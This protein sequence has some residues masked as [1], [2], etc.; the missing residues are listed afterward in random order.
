MSREEDKRSNTPTSWMDQFKQST[1]RMSRAMSELVTFRNSQLTRASITVM[2]LAP[3][4]KVLEVGCGPGHALKLMGA[5]VV[6]GL[7]AGIDPLKEMVASAA[8][9]N[10]PL[11]KSGRIILSRGDPEKIPFGDNCFNKAVTINTIHLWKSKAAGFSEMRRVLCPEG[12]MVIG[13]KTATPSSQSLAD[14]GFTAEEIIQLMGFIEQ[15]GFTN[16]RDAR[17]EF[18]EDECMLLANV[19]K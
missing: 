4:D 13:L 2:N 12:L 11:L 15:A 19:K 10:L 3:M 17:S 7:V 9:R 8:K 18:T 6:E 16:L 5:E 14:P 1:A